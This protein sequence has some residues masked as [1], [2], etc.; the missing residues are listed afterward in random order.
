MPSAV[1]KIRQAIRGAL[2]HSSITGT[3]PMT[4]IVY[5]PR[6]SLTE[7]PAITFYDFGSRP[8]LK[9][10]IPLLDRTVTIDVWSK[11][12]DEAEAIAEAVLVRLQGGTNIVPLALPEARVRYFALQSDID[13]PEEDGE[14]VRKTLEYRCLAY[15][16]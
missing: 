9:A 15:A 11:T 16:A 2:N 5:R 3:V 4:R 1:Q 13:I 10:D 14:V 6:K 7:F 12:L 8:D